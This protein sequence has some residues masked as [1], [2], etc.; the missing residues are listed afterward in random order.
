MSWEGSTGATGTFDSYMANDV[1][2]C[3]STSEYVFTLAGD[4]V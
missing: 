2:T 1:N 4:A 3:K